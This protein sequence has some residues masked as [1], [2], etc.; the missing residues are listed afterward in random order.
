MFKRIKEFLNPA[1]KYSCTPEEKYYAERGI[2]EPV[3]AILKSINERGRDWKIRH[4]KEL[5]SYPFVF[6]MVQDKK[7]G[8]K[9]SISYYRGFIGSEDD[10]IQIV[11]GSSMSWATSDEQSAITKK[12]KTLYLKRFSRLES[13]KTISE[14]RI[15]QNLRNEWKEK[16]Q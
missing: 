8:L 7:T 1:P 5:S 9:F 15:K 6:F 11:S 4:S 12:L 2:S 14:N 10:F 16:Y 3:I 13:I